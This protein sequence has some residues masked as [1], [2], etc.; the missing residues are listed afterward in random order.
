MA[1]P[2]LELLVDVPADQVANV[3]QDFKDDD[4]TVIKKKQQASGKWSVAAAKS[5]ENSG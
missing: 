2:I 5:A 4:F 3:E 1:D